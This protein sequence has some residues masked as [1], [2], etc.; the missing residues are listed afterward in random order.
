MFQKIQPPSDGEKIEMR[1]EKLF[2]PDNPI[3]PYFVGDGIGPDIFKA[4]L[5]TLD[6]AVQKAYGGSKKISWFKI[7]AGDEARAFYN[8]ELTDEEL[9][10]IPI[11]EQRN[12]YLPKDTLNAIREYKV[13]LKGPLTTP[14]GEGFRSLN[15]GIRQIL[16]LYVCVRPV[17]Y[18]QGVPTRTKF[19]EELDIVI[20]RENS[21]DVYSGIE[22]AKDDEN[23]KKLLKLLRSMGKVIREDSGIGIKPISETGSKRLVRAA[24]KYAIEKNLPLVTLVHKGNIMKYTEG[25]FKNWGYEVATSEFREQIITEDELWDKHDGKMPEGK[26]LINDRIADI[27]FQHILLRSSEFS[28]LATMNLNGDYISD[29]AAAIVGGLGMAPGA[30]I[31]YVTGVMV[32]EATHGT[33]PKYTDMDKVNPS[34]VMLSAA[35]MFDY[36]GWPEAGEL[37]QRGIQRAV[38]NKEVTYDLAR[39]MDNVTPI[40]CSE[41]GHAVVKYM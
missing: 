6:A 8:P 38:A 13:A 32:A 22:F 20:F 24:I 33:A 7:Y 41:F 23:Q 5:P 4:T 34:S 25:A 17:K 2:V 28:V 37:I 10:K 30:N 35:I 27:I 16:D 1:D 19:P 26:I 9:L 39:Q 18:F 31:N 12:V 36:M 11:D 40:K 14:I 3:I 21:E 15:V 29:A